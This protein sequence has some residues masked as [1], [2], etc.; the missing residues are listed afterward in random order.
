MA[1]AT[2]GEFGSLIEELGFNATAVQGALARLVAELGSPGTASD[3][4]RLSNAGVTICWQ[5]FRI[6]KA[7]N[8]LDE[9]RNIPTAFALRKLFAAAKAAGVSKGTI[10]NVVERTT[11]FEEFSGRVASDK[12]T[13][14]SLIAGVHGGLEEEKI[15]LAQRRAAYRSAS[16]IRGNQVDLILRSA[17]IVRTAQGVDGVS[18]LM[19]KGMR[20]LR[21]DAQLPLYSVVK[22]PGQKAGHVEE[23]LPMDQEA[24][25]H[26]GMP[27]LPRFSSR[28]LPLAR[29]IDSSTHVN[30]KL[31]DGEITGK[32]CGDVTI[33]VKV[34]GAPFL[35]EADGRQLYCD[36][37]SIVQNPCE[38][39][40]HELLLHRPT[41]GPVVPRL[42][43]HHY[44]QEPSQEAA[45]NAQQFPV[46]ET[47]SRVGRAD[48]VGLAE[49]P[50]YGELLG[51]GATA[52]GWNLSEFDVWRVKMPY[53]I[54]FATS[55]I[56]FYVE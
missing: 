7:D 3:L 44:E 32:G 25:D 2:A 16:H 31:V 5:V 22:D 43:I 35:A 1:T 23:V 10:D 14:N 49:V 15:Q 26:H 42:M 30:Y 6:I 40:V 21:P 17:M 48:Q 34:H 53:P 18:F 33:G 36:S 51:Y 24:M 56:W 19:K 12:A 4:N 47:L 38:M 37:V 54:M 52:A 50:K 28:P 41:F 29:R 11:A 9:A 46:D 8:P 13:F 27:V 45:R 39:L 20:R 55:R